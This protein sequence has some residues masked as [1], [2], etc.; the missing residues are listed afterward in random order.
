MEHKFIYET[1]DAKQLIPN[2]NGFAKKVLLEG[3]SPI[4]R[5]ETRINLLQTGSKITFNE[6]KNKQRVLFFTAGV[7]EIQVEG[8]TFLVNIRATFT[9]FPSTPFSI[10]AGESDLKWIE[11]LVEHDEEDKI[12]VEAWK[13]KYPFFLDYNNCELYTD[14]SK[15]E[16]T[17]KRITIPPHMVP[18]FAMGSVD[19]VGPDHLKKHPH[20]TIDQFFYGFEENDCTILVDDQTFDFKGDTLFYIPLGS[21]HGVDVAENEKMHYMW[22]DFV[23]KPDDINRLVVNHKLLGKRG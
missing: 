4:E 20:P 5:L 18:R 6:I 14:Y 1:L 9:S 2:A 23:N 11:F 16:K 21:N 13:H 12:E 22:I 10:T 8:K 15:S 3:K 17:V 7:G 19:S